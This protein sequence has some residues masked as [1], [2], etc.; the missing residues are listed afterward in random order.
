VALIIYGIPIAVAVWIIRTL[1]L[2]QSDVTTMQG[3]LSEI[4]RLLL[5]F[6]IINTT[7]KDG[8]ALNHD[9]TW[10]ALI[11]EPFSCLHYPRFIGTHLRRHPKFVLTS[12]QW[13]GNSLYHQPRKNANGSEI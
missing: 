6:I 8:F 13:N 7:R 3:E 1:R 11:I 10:N 12:V 4:K 5:N 2:V 9:S